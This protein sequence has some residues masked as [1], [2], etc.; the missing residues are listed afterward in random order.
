MP[1]FVNLEFILFEIFLS[2]ILVIFFIPIVKKLGLKF[3][4][5]DF[6]N[7]RKQHK[8]PMVRVGGIAIFLGFFVLSIINLFFLKNSF[9]INIILMSLIFGSCYFFVGLYEDIFK[10]RPITRLFIEFLIASIF[11]FYNLKFDVINLNP[12]S[13]ESIF[14]INPILSFIITNIWIVGILNSIN[15]IDGLD[16]LAAGISSLILLGFIIIGFS[17][18]N[19]EAVFISITIFGCCLGFLKYNSYPAKILMGDSGSYFLGSMLAFLSIFFN[20]SS[21][22]VG[23]T[24]LIKGRLFL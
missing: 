12:L 18:N 24:N 11:W 9:N 6:P 10:I 5:Y 15:W 21:S 14:Y 23:V 16:G 19:M 2:I 7:H 13:T 17:C 20:L 1:E 22:V 3:N 4:L 8:N